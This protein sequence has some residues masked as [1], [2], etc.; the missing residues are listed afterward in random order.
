MNSFIETTWDDVYQS[1]NATI[2]QY[3]RR[4][5]ADAGINWYHIPVLKN[6][7][8]PRHIAILT[9][10]QYTKEFSDFIW[11]LS[12]RCLDHI[13]E[14]MESYPDKYR[15]EDIYEKCMYLSAQSEDTRYPTQLSGF[16][17]LNDKVFKVV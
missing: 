3:V 11:Q 6:I 4:L 2:I 10:E 17:I 9:N 1:Y 8:I 15:E 7:D 5:L 13:I 14:Y 16:R 12:L